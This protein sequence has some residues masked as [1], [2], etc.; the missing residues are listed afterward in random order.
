MIFQFDLARLERF[1]RESLLGILDVIQSE[2]VGEIVVCAV[3]LPSVYLILAD[4]KIELIQSLECK[5]SACPVCQ[6]LNPNR[7][8]G[9]LPKRIPKRI[10]SRIR[11]LIR[12]QGRKRNRNHRMPVR[13]A[14][15][16]LD[17]RLQR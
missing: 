5:G 14:R 13:A 11:A 2:N 12:K 9:Q 1:Q 16:A 3:K 7:S 6:N 17:G 8:H 15:F 10:R 4:S